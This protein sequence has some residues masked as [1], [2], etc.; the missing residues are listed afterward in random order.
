M[1]ANADAIKQ[2]EREIKQISENKYDIK[3]NEASD[4]LVDEAKDIVNTGKRKKCRYFGKGFCKYN[5]KCQEYLYSQ[6][7]GKKECGQRHPKL[8]R[9]NQGQRGCKRGV[10]CLYLHSKVALDGNVENVNNIDA[11]EYQCASC[12][13]TWND[14][15]CAKEHIIKSTKVFF[16]LNCDNWVKE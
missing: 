16:C 12:R 14:R 9:W 10:D 5:N 8:C 13:Y 11:E 3:I 7:C 6:K 2:I 15:K 1:I 4:K